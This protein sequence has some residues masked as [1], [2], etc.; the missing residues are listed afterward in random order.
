MD[1]YKILNIKNLEENNILIQF[2]D[3]LE[4]LESSLDKYFLIGLEFMKK[5]AEKGFFQYFIDL[6]VISILIDKLDEESF[7]Y[8]DYILIFF[9]ILSFS[10][11]NFQK[12]FFNDLI[13]I[14]LINL[15]I[16]I[17][18][19]KL[20][21][22]FQNLLIK[23]NE[24][25]FFFNEKFIFQYFNL[26]KNILNNL[27]YFEKFNFKI[28]KHSI[29]FLYIFLYYL[30]YFLNLNL[31]LFEDIEFLLSKIFF[32]K[33]DQIFTSILIFLKY[34]FN[35]LNSNLLIIFFK[36]N[37]FK[38]IFQFL[39]SNRGKL[40]FECFSC[41][42]SIFSLNDD[43]YLKEGINNYNLLLFNIEIKN[44][45]LKE[46]LKFIDLCINITSTNDFNILKKFLNS[47][48]FLNLI[49]FLNDFSY[50]LLLKFS[51]IIFNIL[52]QKNNLL[53]EILLNSFNNLIEFIENLLLS[54]KFEDINNLIIS[55]YYLLIYLKIN[56]NNFEIKE[57]FNLILNTS[58]F[59]NKIYKKI[60][61]I[62]N[63]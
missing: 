36:L 5:L 38:F 39:N 53:N 60:N 48:W 15:Y 1:N 10:E 2:N 43:F 14:K 57:L 22:I 16:D 50:L 45:Q 46:I 18:S 27:N 42:N 30:N 61:K 35:Y 31:L 20:L 41:L 59:S 4:Y 40:Q 56:L 9:K 23:N 34:F 25:I 33:N 51:N 37:Y 11:L 49:K 12:I 55:Y 8:I 29:K 44:L 63:L 3:Y 52:I 24:I 54:S 62:L 13:I 21:D 26:F 58:N 19:Y 47:N 32:I 6:K 17:N 7:N 28:L